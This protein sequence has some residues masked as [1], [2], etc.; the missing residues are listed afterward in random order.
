[1]FSKYFSDTQREILKSHRRSS[2]PASSGSRKGKNLR[3]FKSFF[4]FL[5]GHLPYEH[6]LATGKVRNRMQIF[7]KDCDLLLYH[8]WCESYLN[9]SGGYILVEDIVA[10]LTVESQISASNLRSFLSLTSGVKLL[11]MEGM[12]PEI[13]REFSEET[14]QAQAQAQAQAQGRGTGVTEAESG[15]LNQKKIPSLYSIFFSFS[16]SVVFP[17]VKE[18]L[19]EACNQKD[20][21]AEQKPDIL[22]VLDKG[23]L[24]RDWEAGGEYRGLITEEDTLMWFYILLMEHIDVQGHTGASSNLRHLVKSNKVYDQC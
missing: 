18:R 21:P 2:S 6:A 13:A 17:E 11:R 5:K 3:Q 14:S 8:K 24:V 1:M 15:I 9:L 16:S 19:L 7:S 20:Y 4:E 22:C 12:S 23:I 10:F